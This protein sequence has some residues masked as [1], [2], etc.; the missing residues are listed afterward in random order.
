MTRRRIVSVMVMMMAATILACS[1][2]PAPRGTVTSQNTS[3]TGRE[4][5]KQTP[6][7][8]AS[9]QSP[10][11]FCREFLLSL[12]N[13]TATTRQLTIGFK[14]L[15]APPV[16]SADETLGYS[17]TTASDWLAKFQGQIPNAQ[18][19][20]IPLANDGQTIGYLIATGSKNLTLKVVSTDA[21]WQVDWLY[22]SAMPLEVRSGVT[23]S[24]PSL[25]ITAALLQTVMTSHDR[26]TANRLAASLMTPELRAEIAPPFGSDRLGYNAGILSQKLSELR[27]SS[28]GC[29]IT[30]VSGDT[31]AVQFL[32]ENPTKTVLVTVRGQQVANW[33]VK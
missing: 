3:P 27:G 25:F 15:I 8:T 22:S 21:R 10:D 11:A 1:R 28:T 5:T 9:P 30:A 14:K 12:H 26:V 29:A 31:V 4:S 23:Q 17:E 18:M 20:T 7:T 6:P 19:S 33:V 13:G 24:Q 32:G 2:P 16:F